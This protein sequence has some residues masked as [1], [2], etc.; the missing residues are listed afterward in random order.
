MAWRG[1]SKRRLARQ[2]SDPRGF[3]GRRVASQ[4]NQYNRQRI[5]GAVELLDLPAGA[6]AA[7]IG[8]GGGLGIRL[9][10]DAVGPT[11]HV[12]AIDRSGTA[13]EMGRRTYAE[14]IAEG[15]LQIHHCSMTELPIGAE[16]IDGAITVNTVYFLDDEQ[17]EA[18]FGELAR[19]LRP[20]GRAVMGVGNPDAMA[21]DPLMAHGF[22]IRPLE[23]LVHHAAVA[24]LVQVGQR[25]VGDSQVPAYLVAL[26]RS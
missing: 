5:S 22:R 9:L 24:G 11:G 18:A 13:V 16:A 6:S 4:L 15:R 21:A 12:H 20:S 17:L 8:F 2:L 10:L 26:A 14:S 23:L 25:E 3:F 1:W 19:V 7:D